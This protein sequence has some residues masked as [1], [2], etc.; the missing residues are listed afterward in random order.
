ML[1]SGQHLRQVWMA[2][3]QSLS[4]F[5]ILIIVRRAEVLL[6]LAEEYEC[7]RLRFANSSLQSHH[8]LVDFLL[9]TVKQQP[10]QKHYR[11]ASGVIVQGPLRIFES[12]RRGV[13]VESL[14]PG[15]APRTVLVG[16]QFIR[17]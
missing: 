1:P 6:Q 5:G 12:I 11:C 13:R 14:V 8:L 15:L 9:G 4:V 3:S 2:L 17:L 16:C 7:A 10:Y